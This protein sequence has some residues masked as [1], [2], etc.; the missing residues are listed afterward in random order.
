MTPEI[1]RDLYGLTIP[2]TST[3]PRSVA[4]RSHRCQACGSALVHRELSVG[5]VER[6]VLP[7]LG[8]RPY[9]CL[10]CGRRFWDRPRI[11]RGLA[12]ITKGAA[13]RPLPVSRA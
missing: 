12:G 2:A 6:W 1:A 5:L 7:L 4:G 13:P 8:R 9:Q 11:G 10:D 3:V